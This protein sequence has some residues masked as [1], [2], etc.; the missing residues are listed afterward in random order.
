MFAGKNV[1]WFPVFNSNVLMQKKRENGY[2]SPDVIFLIRGPL[3]EEFIAEVLKEDPDYFFGPQTST[4]PQQCIGKL[5]N[6]EVG[7]GVFSLRPDIVIKKWLEVAIID[8]KY[9]LL[10][11]EY[12][13]YGVSQADIY[14]M[15][16]YVTKK[17]LTVLC[18]FI[19]IQN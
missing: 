2:K 13:K 3:F 14:Q 8:T 7:S 11:D 4:S 15:Y 6:S 19:L 18:F 12:R 10:N 17:A 1:Q 5:A 16:D 9:K